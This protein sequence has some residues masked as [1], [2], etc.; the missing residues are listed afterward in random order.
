MVFLGIS[1]GFPVFWLFS[2][3]FLRFFEGFL[4]FLRV[5]PPPKGG[6]TLWG[7]F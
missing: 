4:G 7:G 3:R 5:S 1:Y 2:S 6:V